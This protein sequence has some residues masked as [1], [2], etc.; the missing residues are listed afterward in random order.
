[1]A[2][3]L[4]IAHGLVAVALLGAITHQTLATWVPPRARPGSFVGRGG[5]I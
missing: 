3:A 2:T 4:L 1:M 5:R